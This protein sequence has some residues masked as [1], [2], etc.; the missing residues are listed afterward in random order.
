MSHDFAHLGKSVALVLARLGLPAEALIK[1]KRK[2]LAG[3]ATAAS[4]PF[5]GAMQQAGACG[6]RTTPS[7]SVSPGCRKRTG[8]LWGSKVDGSPAS[9]SASSPSIRRR[10]IGTEDSGAFASSTLSQRQHQCCRSNTLP[11]DFGTPAEES[12]LSS[13]I[14]GGRRTARMDE[15]DR[16]DAIYPVPPLEPLLDGDVLVLSC[17]LPTMVSFQGSVLSERVRGLEILGAAA[18]QLQRVAPSTGK[19]KASFLELVLS[20]CNHFVGRYPAGQDG[21]LLASRYD[22]RVVAVR[23]TPTVA[24]VNNDTRNAEEG[25][26]PD[27]NAAGRYALPSSLSQD[28]KSVES[29][30]H[31]GEKQQSAVISSAVRG[32]AVAGGPGV[33]AAGGEHSARGVEAAARPLAPGDVVLVLAKEGFLETWKDALEFDLVTEVGAV[34]KAVATYDYLSLLVF[35]GML[36]W[37]LFSSIAMVSRRGGA[38]RAVRQRHEC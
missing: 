28:G 36:G 6:G 37:V 35:C 10:P 19:A 13:D 29:P 30:L 11:E 12:P 3:V 2:T 17:L 5:P 8:G 23:H 27:R 24:A 7:H 4:A 34:P 9:S 16:F 15:T 20:D 31:G 26:S 1:I 25:G 33:G 38:V 22:C 32:G 14:V 18:E 21:A